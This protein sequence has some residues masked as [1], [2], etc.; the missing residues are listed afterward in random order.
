M[1]G[2]KLMSMISPVQSH[3]HEGRPTPLVA[4]LRIIV[5]V[6][7]SE[8]S[9]TARYS[10]DPYQLSSCQQIVGSSSYVVCQVSTRITA[11]Q[12]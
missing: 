4:Q 1:A 8:L 2:N 9:K 12:S 5:T 7:S 3:Y 6:Q 10:S 11:H